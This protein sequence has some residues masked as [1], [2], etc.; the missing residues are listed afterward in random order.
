MSAPV[1]L[2]HLSPRFYELTGVRETTDATM[3]LREI[4]KSRTSAANQKGLT[5]EM[6]GRIGK[7]S[8]TTTT[9]LEEDEEASTEHVVDCE[10]AI[11]PRREGG[12]QDAI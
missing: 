4:L 12:G 1:S 5:K 7:G 2:S 9:A 10:S 6:E 3:A 8:T 11:E